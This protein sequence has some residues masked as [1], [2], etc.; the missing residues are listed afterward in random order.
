MY[1]RLQLH[2]PA[3]AETPKRFSLPRRKCVSNVLA[4]LLMESY[5][6]VGKLSKLLDSEYRIVVRGPDAIVPPHLS[7][8]AIRSLECT[9]RD[10]VPGGPQGVQSFPTAHQFYQRDGEGYLKIPAGLLP[11]VVDDLQRYGIDAQVDDRTRWPVLEQLAQNAST[12]GETQSLTYAVASHP[13]GQL[14]VGNRRDM[15]WQL[16]ALVGLFDEQRIL[17]VALNREERDRLCSQLFVKLRRPVSTDRDLPW[18][19]PNRITVVTAD[20]FSGISVVNVDFDIIVFMHPAALTGKRA[21]ETAAQLKSEL[22]YCFSPGAFHA[23]TLTQLRLEAIC[24]SVIHDGATSRAVV[25]VAMREAPS[26][27]VPAK[28]PFLERKRA[29]W[30]NDPRNDC[31]AEIALTTA[32]HDS[33]TF[34]LRGEVLDS[35]WHQLAAYRNPAIAIVVESTAHGRELLRRLPDWTLHT[36]IPDG[37]GIYADE[38]CHRSIVTQMFAARGLYADVV[39][40]ASGTA[41]PLIVRGFPTVRQRRTCVLSDL[42]DDF[43]QQAIRDTQERIREYESHGWIVSVCDQWMANQ[44]RTGAMP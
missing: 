27:Q 22:L 10:F 31:I 1:E 2:P 16:E 39:I 7:D 15:R 13:R 5:M 32:Q 11:R 21:Y 9:T 23:D 42:A 24:G 34:S 28:L 30:H 18:G 26:I 36:A 20:V 29:I 19:E 14:V 41:S 4:L 3:A 38:S 12:T 35:L 44:R 33:K 6:S 17:V 37:E 8:A 40:R 43:D 25:H